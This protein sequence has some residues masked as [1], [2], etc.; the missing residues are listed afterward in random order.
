MIKYLNN[1]FNAK[2]NQVTNRRYYKNNQVTARDK[3]RRTSRCL[4]TV[5][6]NS[7]HQNQ[8]TVLEI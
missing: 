1:K 8:L 4:R 6:T 3:T 5:Q 2:T 7:F